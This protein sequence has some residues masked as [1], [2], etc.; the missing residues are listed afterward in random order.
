MSV[1]LVD[2][3]KALEQLL[4]ELQSLKSSAQQLQ[5]AENAVTQT[6]KSAEIFTELSAKVLDDSA[7]QTATVKILTNNFE[8]QVRGQFLP[9]LESLSNT[10]SNI[11]TKLQAEILPGLES[12]SSAASSIEAKL[13]SDISPQLLSLASRISSIETNLQEEVMPALKTALRTAR[14][15]LWLILGVGAL[16]AA[17]GVL[18]YLIYQLLLNR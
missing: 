1:N 2:A 11:E 4:V 18:A 15:N 14:L 9:K 3:D 8:T 7:Q 12:T 10:T 16:T 13:Q 6:I 5:T 17:N